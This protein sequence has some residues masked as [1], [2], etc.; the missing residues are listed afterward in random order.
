MPSCNAFVAVTLLARI[1]CR[2]VACAAISCCH[3]ADACATSLPST[4][5]GSIGA[6]HAHDAKR[7]FKSSTA[8]RNSGVSGAGA[9]RGKPPEDRKIRASS[10]NTLGTN[11]SLGSIFP[12]FFFHS[13]HACCSSGVPPVVYRGSPTASAA[14]FVLSSAVGD[15]S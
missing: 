11:S 5:F 3:S 12:E 1:C 7:A 15:G 9:V 6:C 10:A 8:M 13:F 2:C 4:R 14:A